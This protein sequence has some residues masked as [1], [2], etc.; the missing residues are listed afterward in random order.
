MKPTQV[1]ELTKRMF[2]RVWKKLSLRLV[3]F[4]DLPPPLHVVFPVL[5]SLALGYVLKVDFLTVIMIG[6]WNNGQKWVEMSVQIFL[7][8]NHVI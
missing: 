2:F 8:W 3:L 6:V 4:E 5:S 7:I 1:E